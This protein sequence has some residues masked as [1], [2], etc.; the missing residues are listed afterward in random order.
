MT[1]RTLNRL[2]RAPL[3]FRALY[4]TA[5]LV[6]VELPRAVERACERL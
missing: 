2:R 1:P 6:L 4:L 3:W 5:E